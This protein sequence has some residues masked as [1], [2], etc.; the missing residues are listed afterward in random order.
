MKVTYNITDRKPFVKALE[1]ITGAKAVYMKTPTYAYTVDYF[2]V[3]REGNLTFNDMADSE[4]I[5]RVL[6]ELDQRGFHSE[7]A[8]YDECPPEIDCEEPLED[9]PPAY[10]VPETKQ[11][12]ESVGLTVAMPL[13]KVLVGN[14]TNLLEAKGS[15]IR[16]ALGISELPIAVSEEQVSFPWFSDGLDAET[17]KAYTN[18]IAAL[19]KMSREKKRISNIEKAVENEKY[20]FRCFLLRL[21]FVG[22]EY[23]ADRKILLKNL[24]GSSA[25]KSSAKKETSDDEISE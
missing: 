24:A 6:E 2:T 7:S 20:A 8:E 3:T 22:V 13:D 1:E 9:C 10:G 17:V 14:L 5:E 16:K 21:G 11:Q 15:L 19:C 4:K 23:K 25:F 12:G 18:F